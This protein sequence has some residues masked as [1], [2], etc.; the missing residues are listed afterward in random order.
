MSIFEGTDNIWLHKYITL[1]LRFLD[2]PPGTSPKLASRYIQRSHNIFRPDRSSPGRINSCADTI[3]RVLE[4]D[5]ELDY[6][7]YSQKLYDVKSLV[8]LVGD[9]VGA[10][11]VFGEEGIRDDV[12]RVTRRK[13]LE[14]VDL[15]LRADDGLVFLNMLNYLLSCHVRR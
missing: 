7:R 2:Q 11:C 10:A 1:D 5:G 4:V 6:S 8:D 13:P 12:I 9:Y 14:V 3:G 15:G